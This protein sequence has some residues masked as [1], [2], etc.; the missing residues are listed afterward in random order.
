MISRV[1]GTLLTRD[2]EMV[3][4]ATSGGVVYE[5]TVPLTVAERLPTRGAEVELRTLLVVREDRQELYGFLDAMERELFERIMGASGI[6]A[7]IAVAMLSTYRAPRLALALAEEDI[8]AL[9]Q[10]SGIGK[11][12]AERL[13]LDLADKVKELA[14][15]AG[16]A[17]SEEASA[18]AQEAV[19][20]LVALGI[21]FPRADEAVRAVLADE[22]DLPTDELIRTSLA[23]L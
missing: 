9:V 6:G 21:P 18:P 7:R 15:A 22:P 13:V 19:Q 5:I 10:V 14:E 23:N 11:K 2:G 1:R 12:K 3:E 16:S 17:G 4:V 8:P 20:A